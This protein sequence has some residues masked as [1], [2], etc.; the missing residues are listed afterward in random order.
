MSGWAAVAAAVA[1]GVSGLVGISAAPASA[2]GP[3]G[4]AFVWAY[5]PTNPAYTLEG[6][7]RYNSTQPFSGA[8]INKVVRTASAATP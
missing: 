6:D 3:S 8:P 7:Y 4:N 5:D 2:A 1:T